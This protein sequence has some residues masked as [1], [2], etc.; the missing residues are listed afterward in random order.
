MVKRFR[1]V[2]RFW[3]EE[4]GASIVLVALM[5]TVLLSMAALV[6]DGGL[7]YMNRAKLVHAIDA[8]V[9]AGAQDLPDHPDTARA[10]AEAYLRSNNID[11]ADVTIQITDSNTHISASASKPVSFFFAPVIGLTGTNVEGNAT[12]IIAPII[13]TGDL[14]P[15]GVSEQSFV[16][17]QQYHLKTGSPADS[18]DPG[19]INGWF[20]CLQFPGNSGADDYRDAILSGYA[21]TLEIGDHLETEQGNMSGPTETGVLSRFNACNHTPSCTYSSFV[22]SCPRVVV[23]PVI[24]VVGAHEVEVKGFAAFVLEGESGSGNNCYVTGRFVHTVGSGDVSTSA[25]DYG[26]YGVKLTI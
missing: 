5:L 15:W 3:N 21:G 20:G 17:G 7:L 18:H 16:Y 25:A 8:A 11:P 19:T 10:T 14:V 23:V 1:L 22:R 13:A 24:T 6:I 2:K 9:L 26:F 12:A 4:S